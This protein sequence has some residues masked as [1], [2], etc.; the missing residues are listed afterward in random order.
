MES[1]HILCSYVPYLGYNSFRQGSSECIMIEH[2]YYN[3]VQ[4]GLVE[5]TSGGY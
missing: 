4:A 3:R 2:S 5:S 1:M